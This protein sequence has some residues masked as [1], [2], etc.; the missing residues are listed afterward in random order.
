MNIK[1]LMFTIIKEVY[2]ELPVMCFQAAITTLVGVSVFVLG[3]VIFYYFIDPINK[4]RL[5]IGEIAYILSFYADVI[6]NPGT[7]TR[8][9]GQDVQDILRKKASKL[10][11][12]AYLIKWYKLFSLLKI[13]PK[14]K[15]L[16]DAYHGLIFLSN[17][18]IRG[19]P[20][21]N[22]KM[23]EKIKKDLGIH[24]R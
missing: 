24:S 18:I 13:I 20:E 7:C 5:T 19:D 17:S 3:K 23:L 6:T 16:L 15:D 12:N 4:L 1:V 8:G 14:F 11:S 22:Y 2:D 10:I 21:K 9:K